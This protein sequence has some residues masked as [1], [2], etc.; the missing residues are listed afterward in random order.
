MFVSIFIVRWSGLGR[1][2]GMWGGGFLG[3]IEFCVF[4]D[5][6]RSGCGLA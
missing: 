1:G 6:V 2:C 3:F 5:F 4:V